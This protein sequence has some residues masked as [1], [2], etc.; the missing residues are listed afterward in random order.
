MIVKSS[1]LDHNTSKDKEQ[2]NPN[3]PTHT[4]FDRHG[5]P[6]LNQT[7]TSYKSVNKSRRSQAS[8]KV[9]KIQ[10][11][12]PV[13]AKKKKF[14]FKKKKKKI[15]SRYLQAGNYQSRFDQAMKNRKVSAFVNK[16]GP[17]GTSLYEELND[18]LSSKSKRKR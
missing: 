13:A 4:S 17:Y 15:V 14:P 3:L 1:K 7:F 16:L 10:I 18:I 5:N 8:R 12:E 11:Q 9:G 6:R 2:I